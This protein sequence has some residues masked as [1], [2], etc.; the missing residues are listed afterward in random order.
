MTRDTSWSIVSYV[1]PYDDTNGFASK[2]VAHTTLLGGDDE[3][4]SLSF[5][6]NTTTYKY[7]LF[8]MFD[9]AL[10]SSSNNIIKGLNVYTNNHP[11]AGSSLNSI[12]PSTSSPGIADIIANNP[13]NFSNNLFSA[14]LIIH[15]LQFLQNHNLHLLTEQNLCLNKYIYILC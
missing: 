2:I 4:L 6:P 15:I 5:I 10:I 8:I 13:V 1:I 11:K 9:D 3:S 14:H 12:D 7:T